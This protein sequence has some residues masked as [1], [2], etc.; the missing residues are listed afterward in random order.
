MSKSKIPA[1]KTQCSPGSSKKPRSFSLFLENRQLVITRAL[2][3]GI[4]FKLLLYFSLSLKFLEAMERAYPKPSI[5][6]TAL[7]HIIPSV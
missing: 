1:A 2:I 7:L 4:S 6:T 5:I 3:C